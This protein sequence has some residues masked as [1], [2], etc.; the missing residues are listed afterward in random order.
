LKKH[1]RKRV[2]RNAWSYCR[3][4]YFEMTPWTEKWNLKT[5]R[6]APS[7]QKSKRHC[8]FERHQA[9]NLPWFCFNKVP[10]HHLYN[11]TKVSTNPEKTNRLL[12]RL[13][14][15]RWNPIELLWPRHLRNAEMRST[16]STVFD[17]YFSNEQM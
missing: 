9:E 4:G 6:C 7:H 10:L 11:F 2:T 3:I 13:T 12:V 1:Q 14:D 8:R 15:V 5:E 16:C 17:S